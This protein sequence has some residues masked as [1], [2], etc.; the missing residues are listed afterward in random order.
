MKTLQTKLIEKSYHL[1]EK[2]NA[3][4]EMIEIK[5]QNKKIDI[6]FFESYFDYLKDWVISD[7]DYFSAM[8][9]I[10]KQ[11][12]EK[13]QSKINS[14]QNHTDYQFLRFIDEYTQSLLNHPKIKDYKL[15]FDFYGAKEFF[16]KTLLN[17]SIEKIN[18]KFNDLSM[19]DLSKIKKI[20]D[21]Q[22]HQLHHIIIEKDFMQPYEINE[23]LWNH[24]AVFRGQMK[25]NT[26][27][28]VIDHLDEK[29]FLPYINQAWWNK[30]D[31]QSSHSNNFI[32]NLFSKRHYQAVEKMVEV[33]DNNFDLKNAF[34]DFSPIYLAPCATTHDMD[35]ALKILEKLKDKVGLNFLDVNIND[36]EKII[37]EPALNKI[38]DYMLLDKNGVKDMTFFNTDVLLMGIFHNNSYYI[39]NAMNYHL[40]FSKKNDIFKLLLDTYPSEAKERSYDGIKSF[41]NNLD[42]EDD[43]LF[44]LSKMLKQYFPEKK[45]IL[46]L[47]FYDKKI[48]KTLEASFKKGNFSQFINDHQSF[49]MR[50]IFKDY[51][52][53]S[54]EKLLC[55]KYPDV[56][57][58]RK[59]G[60][61][62]EKKKQNHYLIE[63]FLNLRVLSQE[64]IDSALKQINPL[65]TKE[66][67]KAFIMSDFQKTILKESSGNKQQQL[68]LLEQHL[69][70]I[71][72]PTNHQTK[73]VIKI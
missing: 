27:I 33:F 2:S 34:K 67:N 56:F 31:Y 28:N 16:D 49:S 20:L 13:N 53:I 9:N 24:F 59:I 64:D 4:T 68:P 21:I 26:Y 50:I 37:K 57:E 55:K 14:M 36:L 6:H 71:L 45:Y 25:S 38:I 3:L 58:I 29:C 7:D 44:N 10:F 51:L 22:Y 15:P 11:E 66:E 48:L 40:E 39:E 1:K 46:E 41:K 72:L 43:Y 73:P 42:Y 35:K 19:D 65:K 60:L 47:N 52:E 30:E 32:L 5:N 18:E 62:L 54:E 70:E 69:I 61:N 17:Q 63:R 23:K 12:V 8:K